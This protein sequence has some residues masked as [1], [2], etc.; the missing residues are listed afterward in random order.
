MTS[1]LE[2]KAAQFEADVNLLGQIVHGDDQ[3]IVATAGGPVP[4]VAATLKKVTEDLSAGAVV[5]AA[6]TARIA[7]ESARDAVLLSKGVFQTVAAALSKGLSTIIILDAGTGGDDGVYPLNIIGGAGSGASGQ[8]VVFGGSVVSVSISKNGAGYSSAPTI[9]FEACPGLA[10]AA[11][12]ALLEDNV[13]D[14]DYFSV[15]SENLGEHLVLYR[16]SGG[17]AVAQKTYPTSQI[18]QQIADD[19]DNVKQAFDIVPPKNLYNPALAEDGYLY[20]YVTGGKAAFANSIVTGRIPVK[21]GNVYTLSQKSPEKGF[22]PHIYC[23]DAAGNYLG[24]DAVI[25]TNQV[26]PGIDLAVSDPG[27]TGGNRAM[28]FTV[29]SGS[30]VA[31][32]GALILYNYA[33]HSAADFDR[34]RNGA[35]LEL[36]SAATDFEVYRTQVSVMQKETFIPDSIQRS[37]PLLPILDSFSIVPGKNLYNKEAAVDG[38]LIS[39]A[40]GTNVAYPQ[41]ISIG[42]FPV[43]PGKTY[44][45]SMGDPVGFD[46]NHPLYCRD[47]FGAFLGIDHTIGATVG[48]ASPPSNIVWTGNRSVTFT[49]PAGSAIRYVGCQ[50]AYSAHTTADFLRIIGTVQAEEGAEATA[51]Q[52]YAPNGIALL[53]DSEVEPAVTNAVLPTSVQRIGYDIYIR[54]GFDSSHDLVQKVTLSTGVSWTNDT[55]NVIGAKKATKLLA[56]PVDAWNGGSYLQSSGDDSAPLQYNGT[57]IGANHGAFV[58]REVTA[59]GHG[60]AVQDV[61]SEWTDGAGVKWYLLRVVDANKLWFVSQN[62]AVYPAWSFTTTITGGTLTHSSA[63]INTG[64]ITVD[65]SVL[66]QLYPCLKNQIKKVLLDGLTEVVSDGLYRCTTV[67]IVNAYEITNPAS[68]L[69]YVRSQVGSASQPSFLAAAIE[70]DVRRALTYSY[71]ENGSCAIVDSVEFLNQVT[72]NYMGVTQA[73]PLTYTGKQLWEYIPRVTPKVGAVKTWDFAMQEDISGT[74]EQLT[75]GSANWADQENPPDRMAQIVKTAGVAEYGMMVGYSPLRALGIPAVRKTKVTEACF[76]SAIRKQYPKAIN[77]GILPAGS[78]YEIC[79][80]RAYWSASAAPD[81][82]CFTWYRDGKNIIVVADFHKDVTRSKLPLPA[83]FTGMDVSVID[84][85]A[86]LTL[87]GNGVLSSAGLLVSVTGGYGYGVFKLS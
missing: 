44:T 2:T 87:L 85:T 59:A 48:M 3:T 43:S 67:D 53:K 33:A 86:S 72:M 68:V 14:G 24:M 30:N 20:D 35:M 12:S 23:W 63:A 62:N 38:T 21:S 74:F 84:K 80:F 40:I 37:A 82:T 76:I 54:T 56:T 69:A 6:Q 25:T 13:S 34:I 66:T 61:G 7:A 75:I 36:G 83:R 27:G 29:P 5:T 8:F 19:I 32:V 26:V 15:P 51:Y 46:P 71:A 49:I 64:A 41:G 28:T 10:N 60:K 31:F 78:Y 77:G 50:A 58:V 9:D 42:Y 22:Y 1:P 79:A 65:S 70:T 73:N 16:V 11:C 18:V 81:A 45:F 39:Y 52:R 17:V 47:I 57:Y 55:V 4:S